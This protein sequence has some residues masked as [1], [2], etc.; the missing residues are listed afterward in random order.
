[1]YARVRS[2]AVYGIEAVPVQVEVHLAAGQP[3]MTVVGLPDNAVKESRERVRAAIKN[4]GFGFPRR[5]VV[6]NLA[7]ADL[8]KEG[9]AFDLPVAVGILAADG[10]VPPEVL[11]DHVLL[12]EL[13]LDGELRPVRGV[14]PVAVLARQGSGQRLIVPAQNAAE[15]AV[16]EGVSV[17]AARHLQQV[18]AHLRGE[19]LLEP[20]HVDVQRLFQEAQH[21]G[22]DFADVRGQHAVKRALEIAA[23]GGHNVLM[24]GPP[25]SGKTL[26]AQ[27][28]P[29]ILPPLTLEEALETTKIHSIAGKL[30][31][32]TALIGVRP[33]RA[34]HH[35]ISDAGLVGGGSTPMPGEISLAHNGVLFLDELPEFPRSVLELLRQPLEERRITLSRART[36]VTYPANFMLVAAMNPCPCGHLGNPYKDCTCTPSQVQRYLAKLSGPLLDRLDIHIEVSPVPYSDLASRIDGE[37]S[38]AIRER[39]MAARLRQLERFRDTAGVYANAHMDTRLV[40]RFCPLTAEGEALMKQAIARLGLSARAYDRILKVARTIADLDGDERI[41]PVHLA[42]AIQYRSLD[43]DRYF[44]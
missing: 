36:A 21:E 1:M 14:L 18:L 23:A 7:P 10:L 40:R 39:V 27:R 24:V 41:Q 11:A 25:G 5:H 22:P 3:G 30:P 9:S 17:L 8:R 13:S 29:T 20:V 33:F 16:V 32:G 28:L 26:L 38:A 43:R 37:S 31:A 12:G 19:R 42:E 34:P 35:T 6:I 2:G 4:S 44:R 15:A